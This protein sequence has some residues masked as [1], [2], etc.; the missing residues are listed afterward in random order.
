MIY[1]ITHVAHG[2]SFEAGSSDAEHYRNS[3]EALPSRVPATPHLTIERPHIY[4]AETM[5]IA[6]PQGE[7]IYTDEFGRVFGYFTWDRYAKK[8]G[9]DT[10]PIRVLQ[11]WGGS[12]YGGQIIPRVGM[13]ALVAYIGGDPDRPVVIGL[14]PNPT[15]QTPYP[16]PVNKTR[17]TFRSNTYKGSGNIFPARP[18]GPHHACPQ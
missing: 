8:D 12:T 10:C 5:I 14:L 16:L 9:T 2:R 13:E 18:E 17:A 3:F 15:H 7:E 4:S 6:G 1:S 11:N